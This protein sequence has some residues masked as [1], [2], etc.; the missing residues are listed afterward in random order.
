MAT[1]RTISAEPIEGCKEIFERENGTVPGRIDAHDPV[2]RGERECKRQGENIDFGIKLAFFKVSHPPDT[3]F[4][5]RKFP[6]HTGHKNPDGKIDDQP[7]KE[8]RNIE[9]CRL[10]VDHMKRMFVVAVRFGIDPGIDGFHSDHNQDHNER[11]PGY[12]G[13]KGF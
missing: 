1:M 13:G 6:E 11:S 9:V 12:I 4:F 2:E 10:M 5:Q 7:N 3:V 8:K